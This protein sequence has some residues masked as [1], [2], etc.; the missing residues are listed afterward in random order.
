[1]ARDQ[2]DPTPIESRDELVAWIEA[3]EKGDG[4]FLIGTEHEKIPFRT[5]DHRPVPYGGET[6]IRALLEGVCRETGWEPITDR[7]NIIGLAD[8]VGGGAISLEPGG[9]F[10]LSGAP[11]ATLNETA[12]EFDA[13][14]DI[15][16]RIGSEL[17]IGFLGIG[18]SPIWSR[19][20]TPVMPKARYG[21]MS[22]Y[23]PR[24]GTMGLDMMFRTA[25]VQVN[26]DFATEADM[27]RKL[28]VGLALQPL[29]TALFAASPFMD[30]RPTG[31]LSTRGEIWRHTD[32][33]R[34]GLIPFAFEDGMG[35]ERYVD[36][37]LDVP[38]YFVKRGD[39][40]HDVSGASFRDL[41]AGR[42]EALPGERA[43]ISDWAN[44]LST[45]F[46]DV[47]IKRYIEMRGADAGS[48]P[49]MKALPAFWAGLLYDAPA[50]DAAWDIVK[51]WTAEDRQ[52]MRDSVPKSGLAAKIRGRSLQ[53]LAHDVLP[54]AEA[55][56]K[57]RGAGEERWLAPLADVVESGRS[58]ADRLLDAFR[59]GWKGDLDRVFSAAIL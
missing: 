28:R 42:L 47:R 21:I 37:A 7:G 36:W 49:M 30:G 57:R 25:T 56:L 48:L 41:L 52:S 4:P 17:G 40:Y 22:A 27:V 15:V 35:Y 23:M 8:D 19:A 46:P 16:S 2:T 58:P 59:D 9:Q 43:T 53:D 34:T 50:L 13:H 33:D 1:M 32:G 26:L 31:L 6:G 10:E 39:I 45:L 24:V 5:A 38:L 55:G 20:E 11:L 3:G 14:M 18:L 12:A 29:A 54:V 44:H 51:D